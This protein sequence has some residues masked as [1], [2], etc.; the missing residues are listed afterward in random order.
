MKE[1]IQI[2]GLLV[3]I[4]L[5]TSCQE[6]EQAVHKNMEQIHR[7]QGIPV[8]VRTIKEQN[9]STYLTFSSS[10]KGIRESTGTSLISDTVEKVLVEMGD[11]VEKN[12]PVIRF[13]KDNP[14]L[15]Y[16]QAI[17]AFEAAEK[18]F[19][20][21]ENLYNSNGVSRQDYDNAKTQYEVE[22]A[23]CLSVR[24]MMEVKAPL[25]GYITRLNVQAS[26]NVEPGDNLFTISNYD[27]LTASV[28]V[29]DHEIRQIR[30]GQKVS[31]S[32]EDQ[33][34][35]G[36]VSRVDL[37]MDPQTKAFSVQIQ[38]HNEEHRVPSGVTANINIETEIVENTVVVHRNEI[39][40][41]Q[42]DW[43]VYVSRDGYARQ[44]IVQPGMKQGMFYQITAGLEAEEELI[45]RG[46]S[47]VRDNSPINVIEVS[48]AELHLND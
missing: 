8:N 4:I 6:K 9:F 30:K 16:Y 44:Q 13:P 7:E 14:S 45:T 38:L 25:S 39:L 21:I 43:Y 15:N 11:Y 32:W 46:I 18:A 31:A 33:E 22:K 5:S 24:D 19:S 42:D 20:R 3:M 41:N 12:Q 27:I 36:L 26:D 48:S 35:H 10:L 2:S 1:I 34:L 29:A 40:N 28:W 17:A 47:L 37:A 23:N